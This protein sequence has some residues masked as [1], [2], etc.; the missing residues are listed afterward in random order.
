MVNAQGSA[1]ADSQVAGDQS[2]STGDAVADQERS[3]YRMWLST[4]V[5]S[6]T[7][8]FSQHGINSSE[9]DPPS[10]SN[11]PPP[12]VTTPP[13]PPPLSSS[14]PYVSRM[15]H[16]APS[17]APEEGPLSPG[18]S[19]PGEQPPWRIFPRVGIVMGG[20]GIQ[21]ASSGGAAAAGDN[22]TGQQRWNMRR[23][24]ESQVSL[25]AHLTYRIQA[26]DFNT[27]NGIIPDI[28]D[29]SA[30]IVVRESKIHNDASVDVSPDGRFL[31]TLIPCTSLTGACVSTFI[32]SFI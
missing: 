7:S 6:L 2:G 11:A 29:P 28:C 23:N 5:E 18:V 1:P 27:R 17:A 15:G 8:F 14:F 26:W 30:N 25:S 19:R 22:L 31:V 21:S 10:A 12:P 20:G 24:A 4:M 16:A 3:R 13:R 32:Y 9:A